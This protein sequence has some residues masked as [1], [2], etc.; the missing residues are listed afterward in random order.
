MKA[1]E[2]WDLFAAVPKGQ[3]GW[4]VMASFM[5]FA[6]MAVWVLARNPSKEFYETLGGEIIAEQNIERDGEWFVEIA[7]GWSDLSKFRA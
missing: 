2:L 1:R 4:D 5:R 3:V 7:Y 6:S